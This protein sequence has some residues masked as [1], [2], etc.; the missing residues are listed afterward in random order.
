M[1]RNLEPT[2]LVILLTLDTPTLYGT[3]CWGTKISTCFIH[4]KVGNKC[5]GYFKGKMTFTNL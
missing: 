2:N 5:R 1:G 3:N 4:F